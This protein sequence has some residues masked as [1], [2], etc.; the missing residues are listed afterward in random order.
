MRALGAIFLSI[1]RGLD[2]V[3]KFLHLL[4]LLLIFGFIVGAL[5]VSIPTV[6]SKAAL[7][8]APE[9][10]IVDQLSG[11]PIERA[12]SQARGVGRSET[13]VWDLV[14]AIRAAAKDTRI[15]VIVIDTQNFTGAGQPTLEELARAL[16]DFRAT[17]KK[18]IA[19]GTD[20]EQAQYYL[21]A[22]AD[23]V[24]VDP[25]GMVLIDGYEAYYTF[26]KEALDKLGVDIN[27]FRVGAYKSAVEVYSRTDMSPEAKEETV[28]YLNSLWASYQ[29]ATT[30]AR[31]L[32]PDAVSTYVATLVDH[33]SSPAPGA[34]SPERPTHI[35]ASEV[36]LKAG[37]VTGVKSRL[38]VEKRVIRLVGEDEDEGSFRVVTADD[39]IRVVHAEK[40]VGSAGSPKIG[41]VVAAGEILDGDQPPGTIGGSSTA[42]L[43]REARLDDDVKAVVL[44]V[45]SPG[46]SMMAAEEIHREILALK[47]AG[48]PFVVSMGDLAASGGYYIAAPADEIWASPAT[49]T[50]SIGIFAVIP[51]VNKTLGKI[52][53]SV[54]G[55]GTT[56]LSGQLRLDR[57]LGPDAKRFL[58]AIIERGYDEFVG[59]VSVGRK[60][61]RQ[62]IDAIAQGRVWSGVD[63]KRHG[64]VDQLGS[65][66]DAVKS[67]AKRAKLT[68]YDVHFVQPSLS[69]A[70]ELALQ[71]R[72]LAVKTLFTLD[73]R[74]KRLMRVAEKLDPIQQE[75]ER[76]SRMSVPNRLY[77]YC[78]CTVR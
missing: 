35:P 75:V 71:V 1:G 2:W 48:K 36:A 29:A 5:R 72:V 34:L 67:A 52:G 54:D 25:F 7:L 23:E 11:D 78:F 66:D 9:G 58:Q 31:K 12:I 39:Y 41:V 62:D 4:L 65:F 56:A 3:R 17:G 60:K 18:V 33:V 51:T 26:F 32:K 13:L 15:P 45:D 42:R 21:A 69:W 55:V 37:L 63:A 44:R 10:Q 74:T 38:D 47:A 8:I 24:Y 49:I 46:G 6:P 57:P 20:Y 19:Y 28:V 61:S 77:A 14:D 50:G 64:L 30:K 59:R 76:L 53:V 16:R 27:V 68:S 73:Q 70:Q 43:I 40:K 22:Q